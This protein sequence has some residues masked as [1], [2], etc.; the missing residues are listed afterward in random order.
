[1]VVAFFAGVLAGLA[2]ILAILYAVTGIN[3]L[4]PRMW[5]RPE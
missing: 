5:R 1:M 3:A 2:I 4:A